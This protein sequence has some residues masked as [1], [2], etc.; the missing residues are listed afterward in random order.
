MLVQSLQ[1]LFEKSGDD[2]LIFAGLATAL[3]NDM[4]HILCV[5][6]RRWHINLGNCS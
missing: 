2:V 5:V 4:L 6:C 3:Q 1:L